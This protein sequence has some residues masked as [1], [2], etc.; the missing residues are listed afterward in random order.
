MINPHTSSHKLDIHP[1]AV[2]RQRIENSKSHI[3]GISLYLL[4][5]PACNYFLI[6]LAISVGSLLKLFHIWDT[7]FHLQDDPDPSSC[8]SLCI[9]SHPIDENR[10]CILSSLA[11]YVIVRLSVSCSL[12]TVLASASARAS[13]VL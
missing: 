1:F 11:S 7:K 5:V 2:A 3:L 6:G 8:C 10:I 4:E 13:Q 12:L 9:C